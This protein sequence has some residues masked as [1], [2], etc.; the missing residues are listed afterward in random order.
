MAILFLSSQLIK[1]NMSFIF[2]MEDNKRTQILQ[3]LQL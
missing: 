1:E 3:E 2:V